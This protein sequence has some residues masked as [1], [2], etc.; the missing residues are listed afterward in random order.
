M[1]ETP[2]TDDAHENGAT[3][4]D[5]LS[6]YDSLPPRR[7]EYVR[8]YVTLNNGAKAARKAGYSIPNA[9]KESA[10]LLTYEDVQEAIIEYRASLA[11]RGEVTPERIISE[12]GEIAFADLGD[13]ISIVNGEP[14][15][16]M[17]ELPP[18]AT[19]AMESIS[20]TT[21]GV[22]FK[23]HDKQGALMTLAKI[24]GMVKGDGASVNIHVDASGH[25]AKLAKFTTDELRAILDSGVFD[26]PKPPAI[27][28]QAK[29]LPEF[30]APVPEFETPVAPMKDLGN[31][32]QI[33]ESDVTAT[34]EG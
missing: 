20:E 28:A 15:L 14:V 26:G 11:D 4:H 12:L 10:R 1:T 19:R 7:R 23:L 9:R 3:P 22:Q 2:P 18:G 8:W 13:Y 30:E 32:S 6:T 25:S 34:E 24:Y 33:G 31:E 27:E 21:N 16:D 29:T 5:T 17:S